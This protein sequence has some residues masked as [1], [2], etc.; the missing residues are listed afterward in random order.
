M[1]K[2][3]A[4]IGET[5]TDQYIFGECDRVCPEA[6]ALCFNHNNDMIRTNTGMAG[7][8]YANLKSLD[9]SNHFSIDLISPETNIIKKRFVDSRYNTIVFREDINDSADRISLSK[10]NFTQYDF[11]I[12]SDYCKGFLLEEDIINICKLKSNSCV[13]FIDTKKRLDILSEYIDC[14]KIN[15]HELKQNLDIIHHIS[16]NAKLI[17]TMGENGAVL[18][19]KDT[20][21]HYPTNKVELRD[22]CGAGDTFLAGLV[23]KIGRAHV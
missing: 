17:V 11:I 23:A 22:V 21:K 10:Y 7:N 8:V 18:Y 19:W 2:K 13:T 4:I 5:C 16:N 20:E 9:R 6:A 14:I 1:T 12:F 3:V 15:H